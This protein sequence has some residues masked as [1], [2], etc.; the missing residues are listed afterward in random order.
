MKVRISDM[1][2]LLLKGYECLTVIL[3][4]LVTFV[5]LSLIYKHKKKI[6]QTKGRSLML[7][8]FIM[9]IFAVFYFTGVGTI[10]DLQRYGIQLNAGQINLLP[11]SKDIDI[12]AYFLNVLLFVP[13]GFF[14]PF[15][16][17]NMDKLKYTVLSGFSFSLLVEISQLFNNR[18]TDIDD[19][20][21]NTLGTLLGYLLF[22]MFI[23]I[24]KKTVPTINHLKYE[25]AIYILTTFLGR[26]LMFNEFGLAKI[27][28][29]F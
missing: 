23:R 19:L 24:T 6:P 12:A 21:L 15:I 8:V 22:K 9:Y 27:L 26:F 3:P 7:A 17:P 11:F 13:F 1:N 10:F 2:D 16:W 5:I 28:Y 18:R 29:G 14:L 4:F 25:P 20:I